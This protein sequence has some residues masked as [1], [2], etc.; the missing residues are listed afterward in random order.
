[1][2]HFY[3]KTKTKKQ[4]SHSLHNYFLKEFVSIYHAF[5]CSFYRSDPVGSKGVNNLYVVSIFNKFIIL[6]F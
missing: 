3:V 5:I 1:M 2:V 6:I 4:L